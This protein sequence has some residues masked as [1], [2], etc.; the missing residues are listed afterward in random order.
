MPSHPRVTFRLEP[1][2]AMTRPCN[3]ACSFGVTVSMSAVVGAKIRSSTTN[4]SNAVP[5]EASNAPNSTAKATMNRR[6]KPNG[7]GAD[8]GSKI[9]G[10][11]LDVA[12]YRALA[13]F[14]NRRDAIP[15]RP[16]PRTPS[17]QIGIG[18]SVAGTPELLPATWMVIVALFSTMPMAL[19]ICTQ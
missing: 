15:A 1:D 2:E 14:L 19:V 8:L 12:R 17:A 9:M 11:I 7:V 18:P 6:A 10:A 16:A 5:R 13:A 3:C 4:R